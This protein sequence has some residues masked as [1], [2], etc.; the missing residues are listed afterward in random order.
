MTSHPSHHPWCNLGL[1]FL[2]G[3]V[4]GLITAGLATA[5]GKLTFALAT[6]LGDQTGDWLIGGIVFVAV[7]LPGLLVAAG[8]AGLAGGLASGL[9]ALR[10]WRP[11]RRWLAAWLII[12]ALSGVGVQGMTTF[13]AEPRLDLITLGGWSVLG[14]LL[15][16]GF[17]LLAPPWGQMRR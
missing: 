11:S 12:W 6:G 4:S 3:V 10:L 15:A 1:M 5:L 16:V 8:G 9:L 14:T 17:A 7:L 2:F 13:N